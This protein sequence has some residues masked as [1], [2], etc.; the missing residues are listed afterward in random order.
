MKVVYVTDTGHYMEEDDFM[1]YLIQMKKT[2]KK[3]M[4]KDQFIELIW[5]QDYFGDNI[6]D[7]ELFMLMKIRFKNLL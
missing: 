7:R 3:E 5:E 4:S 2:D 1:H 6:I